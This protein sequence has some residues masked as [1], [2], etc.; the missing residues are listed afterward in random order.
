M[1]AIV[2]SWQKRLLLPTYQVRSAAAYVKVSTDTVRRWQEETSSGVAI[3]TRRHGVSLSYFQLQE[4]AIVAAMRRLGVKLLTIRL[5]RDYLAKYLETEFPFADERV[6]S[7]GQ[8]ILLLATEQFDRSLEALIVAN[9]GGQCAWPEIIGKRF[10]EFEYEKSIALRWYL[11]GDKQIVIDP[12]VCF[13]APT[14]QGVQTW[15]IR[16]REKAGEAIDEI[17]DDFGL[18][19]EN[20]KAALEFEYSLTS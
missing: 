18:T 20:V 13:G 17:A 2:E 12:R 16:G 15:V 11:A 6:K 1:N 10:A 4:L 19:V 7:D 3:S 14:V 8:D 9:R 5:A